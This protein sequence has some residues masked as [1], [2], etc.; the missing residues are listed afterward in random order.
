[1]LVAPMLMMGRNTRKAIKASAA[2]AAASQSEESDAGVGFFSQAVKSAV[3]LNRPKPS[4]AQA[5]YNDL[6]RLD[7][8]PEELDDMGFL[9]HFGDRNDVTQIEVTD[10]IN[11]NNCFVM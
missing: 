2:A 1:M 3:K 10:F 8:K 9:E 4:N 5:F 6:K 7:V 11:K